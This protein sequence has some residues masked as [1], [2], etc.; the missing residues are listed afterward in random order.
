MLEE[1]CMIN[2]FYQNLAKYKQ[3]MSGDLVSNGWRA[4]GFVRRRQFNWGGQEYEVTRGIS[5]IGLDEGGVRE[6][7]EWNFM[8][9]QQFRLIE[10]LDQ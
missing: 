5:W 3:Q 2:W 9:N 1:F 10:Y 7:W 8:S 4:V 6:E